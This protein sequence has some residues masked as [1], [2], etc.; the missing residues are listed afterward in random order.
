MLSVVH[1]VHSH[2]VLPFHSWQHYTG[3]GKEWKVV[4]QREKN[5][6][7]RT[8]ESKGNTLLPSQQY[9]AL[10]IHSLYMTKSSASW[11]L[12]FLSHPYSNSIFA[13][14]F[15]V[16]GHTNLNIPLWLYSVSTFLRHTQLF[17]ITKLTEALLIFSHFSLTFL[18]ILSIDWYT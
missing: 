14:S 12:T 11:S 16:W 18:S 4:S 10:Y 17:Y 13:L 9:I 5:K 15:M 6:N 3:C 7:K 2:H 8:K 1:A